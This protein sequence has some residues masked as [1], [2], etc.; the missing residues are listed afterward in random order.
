M[1]LKHAKHDNLICSFHL[2][3]ISLMISVIQFVC[4]QTKSLNRTDEGPMAGNEK[5][6]M[7]SGD[8]EAVKGRQQAA[9]NLVE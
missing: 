4:T 2:Y 8:K 5:E 9:S 3:H 7:F 1:A 6:E